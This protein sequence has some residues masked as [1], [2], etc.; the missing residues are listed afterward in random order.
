MASRRP[1]RGGV[2]KLQELCLQELKPFLVKTIEG[3]A[4]VNFLYDKGVLD[5]ND[6]N[7][8]FST[9]DTTDLNR[10]LVD[11]ITMRTPA[12]FEAFVEALA[13]TGH[14]H[15]AKTIRQKMHEY[16]EKTEKRKR[17]TQESCRTPTSSQSAP[18]A[19]T[20]HN[21]K[22]D[23]AAG[24]RKSS[25]DVYAT[26]RQ[27]LADFAQRTRVEK[28]LQQSP[29]ERQEA[30]YSL[31]ETETQLRSVQ[32]EKLEGAGDAGQTPDTFSEFGRQSRDIDPKVEVEKR[33]KR[34]AIL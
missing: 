4:V 27:T 12:G 30:G 29:N 7:A 13:Q 33:R 24:M 11:K 19:G 14:G 1:Q 18:D 20:Q 34:C 26:P 28:E 21:Q 31:A 32:G 8:L 10:H 2:T 16:E 17:S 6:K 5:L 3:G 15:A 9:T 23:N 22:E 25:S